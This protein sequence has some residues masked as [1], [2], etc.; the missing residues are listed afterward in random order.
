MGCLGQRNLNVMTELFSA[1]ARSAI[2]SPR[3]ILAL[4]FLSGVLGL[5][6]EIV[7]LNVL[8]IYFYGD[9][10]L[11][12]SS[13]LIGVFAGLAIS[14]VF[15]GKLVRHLWMLELALGGISLALGIIIKAQG[16]ELVHYIPEDNLLAIATAFMSGFIPLFIIGAHIP[17][18]NMIIK[19]TVKTGRFTLVYAVYS[20]AA[21]AAIL[22]TAYLMIPWWG[23]VNCIIVFAVIN[24][25]L[26]VILYPTCQKVKTRF[27]ITRYPVVSLL[28]L[29]AASTLW[30]SMFLDSG[31]GLYGYYNE[32][33]ILV[34]FVSLLGNSL[35]SFISYKLPAPRFALY[36]VLLSLTAYI[37]LT[38]GVLAVS[39]G[40]KM[41]L[42][43]SGAIITLML[44]HG[45]LVFICFGPLVP[46]LAAP[47]RN[48]SWV[49][50]FFSL[51]NGLGIVLHS[52]F[53][54]GQQSLSFSILCIVLLV[55]GYLWATAPS[56]R[57]RQFTVG[58][59]GMVL[60]AAY[61]IY[62]NN[63][64]RLGIDS[65]PTTEIAK[66]YQQELQAGTLS[67]ENYSTI[68][69]IVHV[70]NYKDEWQIVNNGRLLGD[71]KTSNARRQ[72]N[73]LIGEYLHA[74]PQEKIYIIGSGD[75]GLLQAISA[76]VPGVLVADLTPAKLKIIKDKLKL[77]A[78]AF[79]A[80]P[81]DAFIRLPKA[82][83]RYDKI[84]MN[85]LTGNYFSTAKFYTQEFFKTARQKLTADGV[86][87]IK[88][89]YDQEPATRIQATLN[90]TFKF[91]RHYQAPAEYL[92]LC[93]KQAAALS[94]YQKLP[95]MNVMRAVI[96]PPP[97][98]T[99]A[100]GIIF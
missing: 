88:G 100:H 73:Y 32:I 57:H 24:L 47:R 8:G 90:A 26:G 59:S 38:P 22:L 1:Y 10:W 85:D 82:S 21:A 54:R 12:N 52:L 29:G 5:A 3:I 61:Y 65:R 28:V 98:S 42:S 89:Q 27:T 97:L 63:Q 86:F 75:G 17:C 53:L 56:R 58:L 31:I 33:I 16:L 70:A 93:G 9:S 67:L 39:E 92:H 34:I 20:L 69:N 79:T 64:I 81:G 76:K 83:P 14:S 2:T 55:G 18:Y 48:G 30:Q 62:P 19:D 72:E 43:S 94:R 80:L 74:Q 87:I 50:G 96:P 46:Q 95:E 13:I 6:Y 35:G 71:L 23:A 36:G 25:V 4:V 7:Y 77:P 78:T 91:C 84:I 66:F 45:L 15:A 99:L 60:L 68:N 37:A 41:A 40:L 51:G 49:L 11:V 44:G